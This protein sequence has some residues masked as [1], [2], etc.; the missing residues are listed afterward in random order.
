MTSQDRTGQ[1]PTGILT[2]NIQKMASHLYSLLA[3]KQTIPDNAIAFL[4]QYNNFCLNKTE[5]IA[6]ELT[7]AHYLNGEQVLDMLMNYI[8]DKI[9]Y[10]GR[11]NILDIG[12]FFFTWLA[13]HPE[14]LLKTRSY[15][16]IVPIIFTI[17]SVADFKKF[18]TTICSN[19]PTTRKS[20]LQRFAAYIE[21][22]LNDLYFGES[23]ASILDKIIVLTSL[24]MEGKFPIF[25][26]YM[27]AVF[28][29]VGELD[30]DEEDEDIPLLYGYV[31]ANQKQIRNIKAKYDK[32]DPFEELLSYACDIRDIIVESNIVHPGV[33]S[34]IISYL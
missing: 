31:F 34:I 28:E 32:R 19:N 20:C 27:Q 10:S 13:G 4:M 15:I 29:Y 17:T 25:W 22:Q 18:V 8:I 7:Q 1:D 2:G 26:K 12:P 24:D 6:Y 23:I 14:R 30:F 33:D 9:G 5:Q 21:E 16:D 3:S 11:G